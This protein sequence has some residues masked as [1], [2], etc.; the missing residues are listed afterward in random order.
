MTLDPF[1][2]P[3]DLPA[4]H[5]DDV[6]TRRALSPWRSPDLDASL[7][8]LAAELVALT[9]RE[10]RLDAG[11]LLVLKGAQ[12]LDLSHHGHAIAVR[13]GGEPLGALC[14]EIEVL[15]AALDALFDRDPDPARRL[16]PLSPAEQGLARAALASLASRLSAHIG[17]DLHL[18][19]DRDTPGSL[20]ALGALESVALWRIEVTVGPVRG[21][22]WAL[23]HPDA[24]KRLLSD[25]P[26]P[27]WRPTPLLPFLDRVAPTLEAT[28]ELARFNLSVGALARLEIGGLIV[29]AL[30]RAPTPGDEAGAP[31][32]NPGQVAITLRAGQ[33]PL[34][35]LID[36]STADRPDLWRLAPTTPLSTPQEHEPMSD[37]GLIDVRSLPVEVTLELGRTSVPL[38][39]LARMRPGDVI[40]LGQPLRRPVAIM[41][42]GRRVGQGEL[43][44][45]GEAL[46]VRVTAIEAISPSAD[47]DQ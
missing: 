13:R 25:G 6:D 40:D 11:D 38:D 45:A 39:A 27:R 47:K 7:A 46:A 19:A 44:R 42:G 9:G 5:P 43:V 8:P 15:L 35:R 16:R 26:P 20:E 1:P 22:A 29:G 4:L 17:A 30:D 21:L 33:R 36:A 3:D 2:R 24:L 31:A 14:V 37:E 41:V 32:A 23:A 34:A 18:G 10:V 12:A 28:L